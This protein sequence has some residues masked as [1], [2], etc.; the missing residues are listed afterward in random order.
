MVQ[1]ITAGS[2]LPGPTMR[3]AGEF[4]CLAFA[5]GSFSPMCV[6]FSVWVQWPESSDV[7]VNKVNCEIF[8]TYFVLYY[9]TYAISYGTGGT[10]AGGIDTGTGTGGTVGVQGRGTAG[11][12]Y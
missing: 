11:R 6:F 12:G 1:V 4:W 3:H 10:L 7:K 8:R 5:L 2:G 9:G